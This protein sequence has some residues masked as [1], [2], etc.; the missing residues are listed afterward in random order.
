LLEAREVFID[1]L[2]AFARGYELFIDGN[3][4]GL[5]LRQLIIAEFKR[6]PNQCVMDGPE[7]LLNERSA[8]T[9]G[10]VIHELMTNAAKY[11]ALSRTEGRVIVRWSIDDE[12]RLTFEW[13]EEGGPIVSEPTKKGFGAGLIERMLKSD[14]QAEQS[15]LFA[16]EG[17][18]F[19]FQAP[20]DRV[21]ASSVGSAQSL[22][23]MPLAPE[24]I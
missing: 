13:R 4:L 21:R 15:E 7:F 3:H 8:Q 9:L 1:R 14:F 11:G 6:F 2:H 18:R 20:L 24:T 22:H 12:E 23:A 16:P 19:S 10:L 5:T 17:F